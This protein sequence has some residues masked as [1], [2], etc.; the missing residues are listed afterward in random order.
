MLASQLGFYL[1][2]F[3]LQVSRIYLGLVLQRTMDIWSLVIESCLGYTWAAEANGCP[4]W[5]VTPASN[6]A[7]H[8]GLFLLGREFHMRSVES[9]GFGTPQVLTLIG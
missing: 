8:L 6:R 3:P 5:W 4:I 7:C 9:D 1:P 2:L